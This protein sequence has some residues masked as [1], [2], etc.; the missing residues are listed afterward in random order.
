MDVVQLLVPADGVHVGVQTVANAEVIPL[1]SQALPFCQGVNDG[2]LTVGILDVEDNGALYAAE[3]IVQ[4]GC[5]VHKQGD[6]IA[7]AHLGDGGQAGGGQD[8]LLVRQEGH[9][10]CPL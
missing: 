8:H 2:G 10:Q 6:F 1:Q 3:V 4:A 7:A 9:L 5:A